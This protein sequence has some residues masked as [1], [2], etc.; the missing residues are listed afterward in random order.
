[1][2]VFDGRNGIAPRLAGITDT[3]ASRAE[4]S[5]L[6]TQNEWQR[7]TVAGKKIRR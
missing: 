2:T 5:A 1:M 4:S 6:G 7:G 3:I